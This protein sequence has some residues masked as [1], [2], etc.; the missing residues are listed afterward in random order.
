MLLKGYRPSDGYQHKTVVEFMSHSLS[1]EFKTI[2]ER[3]DKMRKKRNV[4]T[5]E[6]DISISKTEAGNALNT[7]VRFVNLTEAIIRK[8]NP[9][10]QFKF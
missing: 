7:A 10:V 5:Y 3:F 6:V 4:F 1:K 9:Q 8:E 2:V